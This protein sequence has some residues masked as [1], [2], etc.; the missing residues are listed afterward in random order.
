VAVSAFDLYSDG[1][2]VLIERS[3]FVL[4]ELLYEN[5][6]NLGAISLHFIFC[7]YLVVMLIF[8]LLLFN[9][10]SIIYVDKLK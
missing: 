2:L 8:C 3:V 10:I 9:K 7:F 5:K 1:F 6:M 4:L